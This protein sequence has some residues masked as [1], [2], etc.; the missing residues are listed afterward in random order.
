M[1]NL[2]T[3]ADGPDPDALVDCDEPAAGEP[4][5]LDRYLELFPDAEIH[6][7]STS[8]GGIYIFAGFNGKDSLT[9]IDAVNV[10]GVTYNFEAP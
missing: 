6:D 2:G 3:S 10:N 9:N 4:C 1:D 7:F 5:S 8:D